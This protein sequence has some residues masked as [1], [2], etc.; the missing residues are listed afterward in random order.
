MNILTI[1]NKLKEHHFLEDNEDSMALFS[2][3][4][5]KYG[6]SLLLLKEEDKF[7]N[8]LNLLE[9]HSIP[10]QK[11]NGIFAL[12]IFAVDI[13][14][15]E[16]TINK[17]FSIN[18][19]EFLRFYPELIASMKDIDVIYENMKTF[20]EKNITYKNEN[21]YDLEKLLQ[22]DISIED[23]PTNEQIEDVNTY[24]KNKLSDKSLIDK[25][26]N[27]EASSDEEDFN[28]ALELQKV[29]NKICE[30][31]L[32]PVDDGWKIV[33]DKKE[34]NSFQEIKNTIKTI[35]DLNLAINFNDALLIVLFYKSKL[36]VKEIDEI[37]TNVL[38]KGGEK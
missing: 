22:S 28:V 11:L 19:I 35:T 3:S 32:L 38:D 8:I 17:F 20:I 25:I 9:E 5:N 14:K 2:D 7:V 31:Y 18:E 4:F 37:I 36:S 30:D 13:S 34:V 33:I 29:E 26:I 15:I 16:E 27:M 10:L 1:I 12:R 21:G 6:I 23:E 24:L